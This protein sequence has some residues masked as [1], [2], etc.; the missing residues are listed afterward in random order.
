MYH[1]W[2]T[3]HTIINGK[4][5]K[6]ISGG[7]SLT[8]LWIKWWFLSIITFGIYIFWVIPSLNKWIVEHT[9]FIDD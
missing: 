8:G 7:L 9:V 4:R 5:L 2:R 1:K 6:F 3:E